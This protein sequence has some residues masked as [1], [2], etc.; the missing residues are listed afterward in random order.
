MLYNE[1]DGMPNAEALLSGLG[2]GSGT[3]VETSMWAERGCSQ[4]E[5]SGRSLKQRAK[6]RD[7]TCSHPCVVMGNLALKEGQIWPSW[8]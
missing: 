6:A 5:A 3:G 2:T 4:G 8:L 7:Q 1:I